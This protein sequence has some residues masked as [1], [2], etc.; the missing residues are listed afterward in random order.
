MQ[1]TCNWN[2]KGRVEGSTIKSPQLA[3]GQGHQGSNTSLLQ[4]MLGEC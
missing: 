1:F 3:L 2:C 4:K